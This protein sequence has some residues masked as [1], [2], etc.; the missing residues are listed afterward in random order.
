MILHSWL[1]KCMMLFGAAENMQKRL[2]K[3]IE[4][5]ETELTSGRQKLGRLRI[6]RGRREKEIDTLVNAVQMVS[7]SITI[8]SG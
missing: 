7:K 3:S 5:C 1:K 8:N 6:R 4:K 2:V